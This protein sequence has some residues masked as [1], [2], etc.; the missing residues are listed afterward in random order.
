MR[1]VQY[2]VMLIVANYLDDEA[3]D[4]KEAKL[5]A[6]ELC[7]SDFDGIRQEFH[8]MVQDDKSL[9]GIKITSIAFDEF[10]AANPTHAGGHFMAEVEA[11]EEQHKTLHMAIFGETEEELNK[12]D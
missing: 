12:E 11:T 4:Y 6:F 10:D 9:E 8:N 5:E 3:E 2:P 1:S 7:K